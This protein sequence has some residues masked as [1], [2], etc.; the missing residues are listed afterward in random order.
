MAPWGNRA[1]L[2][3][4]FWPDGTLLPVKVT[5]NTE[6]SRLE[7][8][9]TN[10]LPVSVQR[11]QVVLGGW[12]DAPYYGRGSTPPRKMDL[13]QV[14]SLSSAGPPGRRF[15]GTSPMT[16]RSNSWNMKS[17]IAPAEGSDRSKGLATNLLPRAGVKDAISGYLVLEVKESPQLRFDENSFEPNKGSHL[18]VQRIPAE[19]LPS[20]TGLE[21]LRPDPKDN[22]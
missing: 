8:E 4:T 16:F 19:K 9:M 2:A 21:K 1:A 7:A 5:L 10:T 22:Y 13:Y 17:L 11:V 3:Q 18:I 14:I 6:K 15:V 20:F 12:F